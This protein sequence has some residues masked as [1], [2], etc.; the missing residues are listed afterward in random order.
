MK[1][2]QESKT[3]QEP[4]SKS[5]PDK[6]SYK[7]GKKR[8]PA[9]KTPIQA[10]QRPVK[11]KQKPIPARQKPIQRSQSKQAMAQN[12][13]LVTPT[14]C[15]QK[16][17][18][19]TSSALLPNNNQVAQ[20]KCADCVEGK[21]RSRATP[22]TNV[23]QRQTS[24]AEKPT[25]E[26]VR[27]FSLTTHLQTVAGDAQEFVKDMKTVVDQKLQAGSLALLDPIL[28][29]G[30][31]VSFQLQGG[32][33]WGVP[34]HTGVSTT[35]YL[36]RKDAKNLHLT[37]HKQGILALDT[38]V[39][40][41]F[42]IGK[43]GNGKPGQPG[44]GA[45]LG[46]NAQAGVQ[47]TN[48]EEYVIPIKD[49]LALAGVTALKS[50]SGIGGVL[51]KTLSKNAKKYLIRQRFEI[52]AF[53]QGDAEAG[54]GVRRGTKDLQGKAGPKGSEYGT[55]AWNR[56]TERKFQGAK[57][58]LFS[59]DKL[60]LLNA[61]G[62][63]A[64]KHLRGQVV[65]GFEQEI[66]GKQTITSVYGEGEISAMIS[67]PIPFLNQLL[68]MLPSGVGAGFQLS[69]IQEA[70]KK[71]ITPKIK[72]YQKQGED[73][74]YAGTANQQELSLDLG[75]MIS[76]DKL[77]KQMQSGKVNPL[78]VLDVKKSIEGATFFNRMLLTQASGGRLASFLRRQQG[79]RS[80]LAGKNQGVLKNFGVSLDVYLDLK[81]SLGK[82]DLNKIANMLLAK[83]KKAVEATKDAQ[84]FNEAYQL[85]KAFALD[86]AT[87][88]KMWA[89]IDEISKIL[90]VEKVL[91]RFQGSVGVAASGKLS[92]GAKVRGDLSVQGGIFCE[93]DYIQKF[94]GGKAMP[95]SQVM[96]HLPEVLNDPLPHIPNCPLLKEAYKV[97]SRHGELDDKKEK[98]KRRKRQKKTKRADTKAT[99]GRLGEKSAHK[100]KNS[101]A[102]GNATSG[103][104]I[105]DKIPEETVLQDVSTSLI[106]NNISADSPV[107]FEDQMHVKIGAPYNL[108]IPV[109]MRVKANYKDKIVLE[110]VDSFWIEKFKIGSK[111]GQE[112]VV[113]KM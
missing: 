8:Y 15:E 65:G 70:G 71:K 63:F 22:E 108:K 41:S 31:G 24:A 45:E 40:A 52:G 62:I 56:K 80:L 17:T 46:A 60:A 43:P 113:N 20:L 74:K 88:P 38:G 36:K 18:E 33:T 44:M 66:K 19:Q 59:G 32:I 90:M 11:A 64:S 34:V 23:V 4:Q 91:L 55:S 76:T 12:Q 1:I 49:F 57:P 28:P 93:L 77:L 35:C 69:F 84:S 97:L 37:V 102:R 100:N 26:P 53:A 9:Q 109:K 72:V 101:K 87:S 79:T 7:T 95:L 112:Y 51:N 47:G 105:T 68:K 81:Y 106:Y 48:V 85:L 25:E 94:G 111:A 29:V 30:R 58:S 73:Q 39:G 14:S 42:F 3:T 13:P 27:D 50:V 103:V 83:G 82:E 5:Q 107:G 99:K 61:L 96:R 2:P 75:S 10:K 67:L 92:A 98:R 110:L 104:K 86:E 6:A 89:M 16:P 54:L 78:Q 21:K